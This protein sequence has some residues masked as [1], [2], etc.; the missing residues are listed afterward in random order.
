M[1]RWPS[2]KLAHSKL[3]CLRCNSNADIRIR[4][5]LFFSICS[6]S[7]GSSG[8]SLRGWSV[9][10]NQ[11]ECNRLKCDIWNGALYCQGGTG[12]GSSRTASYNFLKFG[13]KLGK[14]PWI[15][16]KTN[17]RGRN[18][19]VTVSLKL[20]WRYPQDHQLQSPW[21]EMEETSAINWNCSAATCHVQVKRPPILRCKRGWWS[22]GR[23]TWIRNGFWGSLCDCTN[24][25]SLLTPVEKQL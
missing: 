6:V 22:L 2:L 1:P 17:K 16:V 12:P 5:W 20:T 8:S 3:V 21:S 25:R 9:F 10:V 14:L 13:E 18:T 15:T 19:E 24:E 23:I 4:T 7:W 11:P